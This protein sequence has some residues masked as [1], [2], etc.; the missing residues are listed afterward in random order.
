MCDFS[1]A[2]FNPNTIASQAI[3]DGASGLLLVP[4]VE[5][6]GRAI[7]VMQAN[8]G[9]IPLLGGPSMYTFEILQKGLVNANGMTLAVAWAPSEAKGSSYS[10]IAQKL[11]GGSG[12]WR[13]AMAY[14]AVKSVVTGLQRAQNRK[15]L[16]ETLSNPEFTIPGATGIIQFM[17]TGDRNKAGTLVKIL[18]GKNSGVGYD[19]VTVKP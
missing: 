12:S 10:A 14:D 5:R 13:T 3:R 4:P 17:P 6:L 16:Q 7:D 2:D 15:Q 19:F 11:W 8:K 18:P 9:K 1:S